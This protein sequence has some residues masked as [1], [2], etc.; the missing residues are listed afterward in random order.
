MSA[1]WSRVFAVVGALVYLVAGS[2]IIAALTD[3]HGVRTEAN[4]YLP[5]VVGLPLLAVWPFLL[6]GIFIGASQT[7]ELRNSMI[8]SVVLFVLFSIY[9]IDFY[10]LYLSF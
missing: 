9:L 4:R 5:W 7:A 1:G 10:C 2:V 3:I 8:I 6:D